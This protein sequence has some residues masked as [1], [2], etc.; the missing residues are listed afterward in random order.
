M[1]RT[2]PFLISLQCSQL[3]LPSYRGRLGHRS[4]SIPVSLRAT[5]YLRSP[6]EDEWGLLGK[7][8]PVSVSVPISRTTGETAEVKDCSVS[9]FTPITLV[10]GSQL[11]QEVGVQLHYRL[12]ENKKKDVVK[13]IV[14]KGPRRGE[15]E[16][17]GLAVF[18]VTDLVTS[19]GR[20]RE[21]SK[22]AVRDPT[23]LS[24]HGPVVTILSEPQPANIK[25]LSW[26]LDV[27]VGQLFE[28]HRMVTSALMYELW[29]QTADGEWKLSYRSESRKPERR[30]AAGTMSQDITGIPVTAPISVQDSSDVLNKNAEKPSSRAPRQ[31]RVYR[32]E[33]AQIQQRHAPSLPCKLQLYFDSGHKVL[34]GEAET[35]LCGL[36]HLK[37]N[38]GVVLSRS[39]EQ[40]GAVFVKHVDARNNPPKYV[41]VR[42][43]YAES[44][45]AK[46]DMRN[47]NTR[48]IHPYLEERL[49]QSNLKDLF[50]K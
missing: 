35:T 42:I 36:T 23:N 43:D 25:K 31:E 41:A 49:K 15:E 47:V 40:V 6:G 9:F 32:F 22:K 2:T 21:I 19:D 4:A 16:S 5:L 26:H 30:V 18:K 11:D 33:R 7:T 13:E 39:I 10:Y 50:V 45:V 48:K 38:D 29:N 14:Q 28:K 20:P 44:S 17:L 3:S 46:G 12:E 24:E 27:E 37:P 34:V 8:E 1:H